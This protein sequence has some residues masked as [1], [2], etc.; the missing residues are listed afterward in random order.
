MLEEVRAALDE[1]LDAYRDT[2]VHFCRL[3]VAGGEGDR[4]ALMGA[5]LDDITLAGV[6]A[7]L[8]GRFPALTFEVE[9]VR[10]L[11][12]AAQPAVVATNLTS[13]HA[14]P[15]WLAEQASQLLNGWPLEILM[16]E[17]RW[18]F[19]RLADGYLG[20]AYRPYL[21]VPPASAPA[22]THIVCAPEAVLRDVPALDAPPIQ[23]VLGGTAVAA[24]VNGA[25]ARVTL[26]GDPAAA[27]RPALAGWTP[28]AGL[29]ALA[30]LPAAEAIRRDQIVADAAIFTGVPHPVPASGG[31]RPFVPVCAGSARGQ[32]ADRGDA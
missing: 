2:R 1:M 14:Q 32:R 26:A 4:C 31:G 30:A 20:W 22:P 19:V 12:A 17:G 25:W 21:A 15:S 8:A 3:A 27:L 16:E 18:C 9:R 11:R 5:V 13:L 24:Q 10:V 28:A 6:L 7:A 23:R 29:R